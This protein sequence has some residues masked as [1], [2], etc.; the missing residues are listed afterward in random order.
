MSGIRKYQPGD[1]APV[2][3]RYQ[4]VTIGGQ[5]LWASLRIYGGTSFPPFS[6]PTGM[7]LPVRYVLDEQDR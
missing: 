2:T 7:R 6:S 1:T 4:L 5:R 3:G